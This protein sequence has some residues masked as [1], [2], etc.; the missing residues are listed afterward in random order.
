[1]EREKFNQ[2]LE[3]QKQMNALK[4]IKDRVD[5]KDGQFKIAFGVAIN[6]NQHFCP[7]VDEELNKKLTEVTKEHCE[8]KMAE[9]E[10]QFSEV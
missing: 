10:K 2:A 8:K 6:E 9:L 4:M 7:I 1:M 3:V 5:N